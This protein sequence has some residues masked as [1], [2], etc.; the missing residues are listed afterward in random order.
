MRV[1]LLFNSRIEVIVISPVIVT[2]PP[3]GGTAPRAL[4]KSCSVVM[5][6]GAISMW[7]VL[8]AKAVIA[9]IAD[10]IADSRILAWCVF[11]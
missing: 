9:N 10:S 3:D 5:L 1:V 4:R 8:L 6:R 2:V 11:S 7:S